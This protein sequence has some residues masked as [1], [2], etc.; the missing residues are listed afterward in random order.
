M[1]YRLGVSVATISR[2]CSGE[3]KPS[4]EL[5]DRIEQV[6]DWPFAEQADEIRCDAY[7]NAFRRRME[8]AP[9]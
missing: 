7:Y 6:L 2:L 8:A 1:A 5:M 3:R 4:M 9:A